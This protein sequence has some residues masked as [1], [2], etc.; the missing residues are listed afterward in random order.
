MGVIVSYEFAGINDESRRTVGIDRAAVPGFVSGRGV[1]REAGICKACVC[2][3]EINRAADADCSVA[4]KERVIGN[5]QRCAGIEEDRA[6]GS[7]CRILLQRSVR[8][9]SV[10]AFKY[11]DRAA[12]CCR[13]VALK[14]A[15][16]C[17]ERCIAAD[18][19]RAAVAGRAVFYEVTF[20]CGERAV[21][22]HVDR[23]ADARRVA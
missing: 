1:L 20:S 7:A 10:T 15:G 5:V 8:Q 4:L 3:V 2:T 13:R 16:S 21:F 22:A 17:V 12:G 14:A 6:A 23:A 9:G 18:E 19:C 11:V